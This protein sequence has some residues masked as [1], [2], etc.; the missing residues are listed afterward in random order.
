MDWLRAWRR[1]LWSLVRRRRTEREID[2]E[3]KLHLELEEEQYIRRGMDPASARRAALI[4]F[5]GVER[6]T[7]ALR[8]VRSLG[9]LEDLHRDVRHALR[10]F[11]RAPG[12][13]AAAVLTLALGAGATTA[14]FSVVH[15]VLLEPLPYPQP[16]R[17]VRMWETNPAQGI[18]QGQVSP[19]TFADL[20]ERTR[21]LESIALYMDRDFLLSFGDDNGAEEVPGAAVSPALFALLGARPVVGRTFAREAPTDPTAGEVVIGYGMWQR[22]FGGS[23]DVVGRTILERGLHPLTIIGVMPAGFDFPGRSEIWF[24]TLS[25]ASVSA[26]QRQFRYYEAIGRLQAGSTLDE[27]RAEAT[28][29]AA[30]L[31]VEYPASNEGWSIRLTRLDE[32][33]VGGSRATLLALLG[34]VGCLLLI[35]CANVANLMVARAL[36]RQ[37]EVAVRLAIGAGSG[38][39]LRQWLSEAT[40][41][42]LLG[43]AAG[44]GMAYAGTRVLIAL[45]PGDIPRLDEVALS[46]PVLLFTLGVTCVTAILTGLAPA[47]Q[48]AG[49]RALDALRSGTRRTDAGRARVREWLIGAEVALTLVLLIS[50][51]L[52]MRSFIMLRGVDLG[53]QQENVVTV[54][55]RAPIGQFMGES[56]PWFRRVEFHDRLIADVGAVAGVTSVAAVTDVPLAGDVLDGSLWRT[57][58][59]G[60]EGR[61]PPTSAADQW[62]AAIP[63][64]TPEYFATMAIPILRGRGFLPLDRFTQEQ[65]GGPPVP[66]PAGVAVINET[67]ARRFFPD[68]DP[69]GRNLFLFDDQTFAAY[70]TIVGIVGDVRARAVA[71]EPAPAVY[72]PFAQHPGRGVSLVLRT[73]MPI[74]ELRRAVEDRMRAYREISVPVIRPLE[75][76][77]GSSIARP[78]FNLVLVASFA[79]VAL[80]LAGVGIAGI[81]GYLVARRTHE[82]G[83]RLALG[84]HRWQIFRIVLGE[85]LRPVL[86]G[87]L[88]GS[89]GALAAARAIR[90]LLFGLDPLDATSFT[91]AVVVL[92]LAACAAALVP[93]WRAT[94]V[95]PAVTL[96]C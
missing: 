41:L 39:L 89:V 52:L 53:F 33:I 2:A 73:D 60:A 68:E 42:A 51:A 30:T 67:F 83:V 72:L 81:V 35:A 45:A 55:F 29:I 1:R 5:G 3:V 6:Y 56:R 91:A 95:D 71:E 90:A 86:L 48:T 23:P 17:L 96:R 70:R 44:L 20:R 64:V 69:L 31:G 28:A 88:A 87:V 34:L 75:A 63:V 8:D 94:R 74:A 43:G 37:H 4:A 80:G 82:L 19:G 14:V 16:E 36:A 49:P 54:D 79:L 40:L 62:K 76:V 7:A 50:A 65:L 77:V 93:A 46:A 25:A 85:G 38:R 12:F 59:P 9:W 13:T 22:R 26:V 57:D 78:R 21:T 10:S 32:S 24:R 58:A 15:A 92:V 47:L 27:A 18:D 84:A 61:R 11:A 66:R